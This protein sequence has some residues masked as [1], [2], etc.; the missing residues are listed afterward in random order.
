MYTCL[1]ITICFVQKEDDYPM[2]DLDDVYK[3]EPEQ[4]EE[5]LKVSV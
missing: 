1:I 3:F 5:R 2:L 4:R